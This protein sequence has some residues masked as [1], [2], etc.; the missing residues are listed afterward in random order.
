MT[1]PGFGHTFPIV[2]EAILWVGLATAV[3]VGVALIMLNKWV[4]IHNALS[5][6]ASTSSVLNFRAARNILRP[7]Y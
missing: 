2:A 1:L 4:P 6:E 5:K 3:F 7:K